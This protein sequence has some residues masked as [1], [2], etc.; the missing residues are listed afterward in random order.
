MRDKSC[1]I[2]DVHKSFS[3]PLIFGVFSFRRLIRLIPSVSTNCWLQLVGPVRWLGRLGS[4]W[5]IVVGNQDGKLGAV[6]CVDR[7]SCASTTT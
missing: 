7:L 2:L 1:F 4:S 6:G 5:A 3:H